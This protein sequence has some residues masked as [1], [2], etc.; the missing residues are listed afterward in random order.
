MNN[1]NTTLL[2]DNSN[3]RT[4]FRLLRDGIVGNEVRVVPTGQIA[5]D[6]LQT[7]LSG[8]SFSSVC[9]SSVVPAA[10]VVLRHAFSCPVKFVTIGEDLPVDFSHYEGKAT[11]GAD[12]IANVIGTLFWNRFPAVAIDL[13]TAVT[14]DVI[15]SDH[16]GKPRYMG[17]MI[18][19]GLSV[20]KEYLASRTALL[21]RL[22]DTCTSNTAYVGKNTEQAIRAGMESGGRGMLRGILTDIETV[23]GT[24]PFV[25]ATG[26]DADWAARCLPEIN[27]LDPLLTFRGLA[28]FV[29]TES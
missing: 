5:Q 13:G 21:P 24:R 11:L 12:R 26:G 22:E 19:P 28:R 17:G 14:F 7:V 9:I 3:S 27:Q 6:L 8:W 16:C 10:A 15:V 1:R 2:I 4:K 18:T 23:I 25:I 29:K 20:F